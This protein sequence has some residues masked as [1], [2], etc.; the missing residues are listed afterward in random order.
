MPL[1]A[2]ALAEATGLKL[3]GAADFVGYFGAKNQEIYPQRFDLREAEFG[4]YGPIDHNFDGNIS[5]AAHNESGEH[6]LEVHEAYLSSNKLISSTT[7]KAGMFFLGIGRLNQSHRHDWPFISAPK[8]HRT[9]FAE[10][11]ATDTGF[12]V[13][14]LIPSLPIYTELSLGVTNGWTFGHSHD[15]GKKPIRPT[16]YVHFVNYFSLGDSGGLQTGLNYLGRNARVDGGMRLVGLDLVAKWREGKELNWLVQSEAY[17]RVLSPIGAVQ[18]KSIGGY[19]FTQKNIYKSFHAG[20]RVDAYTIS[21]SAQKNLDYSVVPTFTYKHSEFTN[22]KL[23]AQWD[24]EKRDHK[25]SQ[26]NNVIELQAFF[27]L[28][29]HPSHDF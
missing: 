18:E 2:L 17:Q 1:N 4:I 15:Q 25:N 3:V 5:F 14:I 8:S 20:I 12:Q 13:N 28:G 24:F 10:E 22:F 9:Y 11:A 7:L 19:F 27:I 6:N 26:T 29:D 23:A 21:S 16:H